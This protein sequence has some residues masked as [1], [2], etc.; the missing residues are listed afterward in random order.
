[1]QEDGAHRAHS[2]PYL[3]AR[4]SGR[5]YHLLRFLPATCTAPIVAP[6][7]EFLHAAGGQVLRREAPRRVHDF[8]GSDHLA[9]PRQHLVARARWGLPASPYIPG[10]G[11]V[12]F[13]CSSRGAAEFFALHS[14]K[15]SA[16]PCV[17]RWCCGELLRRAW[18]LPDHGHVLMDRQGDGVREVRR[19]LRVKF[20]IVV[21]WG[22]STYCCVN[23]VMSKLRLHSEHTY[24]TATI[25]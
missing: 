14:V 10:E 3:R 22:G 4:C 13:M 2:S 6:D 17:Q 12:V 9:S 23:R 11:F 18:C 1:M 20:E 15:L 19:V 8:Q 16:P 21:L 24:T 5:S 25:Q 7:R